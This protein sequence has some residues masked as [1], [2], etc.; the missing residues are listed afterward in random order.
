MLI[1]ERSTTIYPRLLNRPVDSHIINDEFVGQFSFL[2]IAVPEVIDFVAKM[3]E[4]GR[5]IC[6]WRFEKA[7]SSLRISG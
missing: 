7:G 1:A 5:D 3:E 6:A 2:N 4:Q